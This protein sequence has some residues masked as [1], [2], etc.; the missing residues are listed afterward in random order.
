MTAVRAARVT[1][2][3]LGVGRGLVEGD[4]QPDFDMP[5]GDADLLNEEPQELLFLVGVELANHIAD[6]FGEVVDSAV[7][8]VAAAKA[9][10]CSARLVRFACNSR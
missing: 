4:T 2:L 5:A 7:D 10:R 8:L 6:P 1:A 3:V 9:V